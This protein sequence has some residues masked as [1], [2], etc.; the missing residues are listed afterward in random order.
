MILCPLHSRV[1]QARTGCHWHCA[2]NNGDACPSEGH[3]KHTSFVQQAPPVLT[4][5]LCALGL[6]KTHIAALDTYFRCWAVEISTLLVLPLRHSLARTR[7]PGSRV[8]KLC[9]SHLA[10]SPHPPPNK[11]KHTATAESQAQRRHQNVEHTWGEDTVD[12][13]NDTVARSDLFKGPRCLYLLALLLC[14]QGIVIR[15]A[16]GALPTGWSLHAS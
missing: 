11:H 16:I 10:T 13:V 5:A 2:L 14:A 15:L 4:N 12:L 1:C 6:R 3:A 7:I 8:R 9:R